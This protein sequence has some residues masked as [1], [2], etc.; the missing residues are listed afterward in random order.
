MEPVYELYYNSEY[1]RKYYFNPT[2]QQSLWEV[3]PNATI[4]DKRNEAEKK[5][6]QPVIVAQVI[7]Q[8]NPEYAKLVELY[9][10]FF[11]EKER[12]KREKKAKEKKRLAPES[13]TGEEDKKDKSAAAAEQ[14]EKPEPDNASDHEEQTPEEKEKEHKKYVAY[15][16]FKQKHVEE[17]MKRSARKQIKDIKKDMAY[18]EGNYDYNVWYDKYL[19]DRRNEQEKAPSLYKCDPELDTGYTRAD[20]MEKL[21]SYFCVYFARG[22]CAEGSKCR[23]YHRVPQPEDILNEENS[24]DVF[25]RTRHATIK[26]DLSGIG[27]FNRNCRTISA[28]EMKVPESTA[29]PVR[30]TVKLLYDEFSKWGEIED[31]KFIPQKAMAN[32]KY[33]HRFYAEFA[34]EAMQDQ[35]LGGT[36]VINIKWC[37]DDSDKTGKS[38]EEEQKELFMNVL[39][40]KKKLEEQKELAMKQAEEAEKQQ[41]QDI[42]ERQKKHYEKSVDVGN[43]Y[44]PVYYKEYK[45]GAKVSQ[46]LRQELSQERSKITENCAKLNEI[47]QRI[48]YNYQDN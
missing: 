44:N 34:R 3:P 2:N 5:L 9:P 38:K 10:G 37:L 26:E 8:G 40:K 4:I 39:R 19:T 23:Y 24:K 28:C 30:D 14:E 18:Q 48:S 36:D 15:R 6:D 29:T 46:E 43:M 32:V 22:C 16:S 17:L 33:T 25:G 12:A 45:P 7:T 21:T 41:A 27:S 20:K 13:N 35:S 47:L 31:I 11:D 42:K 1:K